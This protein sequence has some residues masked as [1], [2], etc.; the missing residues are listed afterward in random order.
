[1]FRKLAH[2][3][4]A[5][6]CGAIFAALLVPLEHGHRSSSGGMFAVNLVRADSRDFTTILNLIYLCD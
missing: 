5:T 6:R 2:V 1:M 4:H 3:Y